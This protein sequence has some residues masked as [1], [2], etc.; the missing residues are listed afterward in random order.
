VENTASTPKV[1]LLATAH[2]RIP[3]G[4][5][6]SEC[7]ELF[8]NRFDRRIEFEMPGAGI[9][10]HGLFHGQARGQRAR[11]EE[12]LVVRSLQAGGHRMGF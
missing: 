8:A 11:R 5:N 6:S 1:P 12:K 9:V 2:I 3:P 7:Q 4:R 10:Q